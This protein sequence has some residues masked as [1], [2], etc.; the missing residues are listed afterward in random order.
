MTVVYVIQVNSD[1]I[2]EDTK[3][4]G[5]ERKALTLEKA[6]LEFLYVN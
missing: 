2:T 1:H 4:W 5:E 6:M 3:K